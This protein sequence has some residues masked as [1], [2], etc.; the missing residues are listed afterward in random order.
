[1]ARP[2]PR[3]EFVRE[4]ERSLLAP[5]VERERRHL[6]LVVAGWALASAL[7]IGG[8]GISLAGLLP[9]TSGDSPARADPDCRTVMVERLERRPRFV[10]TRD[11]EIQVRYRREWSPRFVRRCP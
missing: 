4:L 8:L 11:G 10:R 9:L 7:A 3:E 2:V 1:M 6:R 5:W